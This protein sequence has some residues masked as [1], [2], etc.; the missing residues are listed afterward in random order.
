MGLR[1]LAS[2][3]ASFDSHPPCPGQEEPT[4]RTKGLSPPLET[5][6]CIWRYLDTQETFSKNRSTFA[7]R[8]WHLI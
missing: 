5:V 3:C 6:G 2:L 1:K 4:E 8:V 7:H